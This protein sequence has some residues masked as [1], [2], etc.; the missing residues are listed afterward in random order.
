MFEGRR[1]LRLVLSHP[2]AAREQMIATIGH[3]LQ[4]AGE[5]V[6]D[7][8]VETQRTSASCVVGLGTFQ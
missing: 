2:P 7:E 3:E 8:R 6:S 5:V 4:H 1:Y